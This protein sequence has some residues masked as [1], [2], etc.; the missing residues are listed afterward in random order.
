MGAQIL[1]AD[2]RNSGISEGKFEKPKWENNTQN[3][4]KRDSSVWPV[5]GSYEHDSFS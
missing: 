2:T 5:A 4:V 1:Q 3:Y